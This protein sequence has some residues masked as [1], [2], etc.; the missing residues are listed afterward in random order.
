MDT[1]FELNEEIKE[2]CVLLGAKKAVTT[3]FKN[4]TPLLPEPFW[5]TTIY[6]SKNSSKQ[7]C[8]VLFNVVIKFLDL[9][10]RN[11]FYC[12]EPILEYAHGEPRIVYA[13]FPDKESFTE[14]KLNNDL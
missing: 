9:L 2:G 8:Y 4:G 5:E 13:I 10:D 6:L 3:F 12:A 11:D 14:K 7:L 1:A